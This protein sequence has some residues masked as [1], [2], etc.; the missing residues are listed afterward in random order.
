M[1]GRF[2]YITFDC[3]GT[4]IDWESGIRKAFV[5]AARDDGVRLDEAQII[6]L[7]SDVERVVERERYRRYR[8][9]LTE[10]ACRVAHALGW[11]VS[12]AGFLADSLASWKPFADTNAALE[13]LRTA[14][15][16][17]GI[18]S[19]VDDDLLTATR[20][21]FS[22]D[23]DVV[24]TAQH[25]GSYKPSPMHFLSARETIATAPWLHAAQSN[26]HDIVPTNALGIANA[27]INRKSNAPLPGGMPT[28][29]YA[30]LTQ[31]ANALT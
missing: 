6:P 1:S 13:R 30:D 5:E 14:G 18:L 23:F 7:Y 11:R 3:Y 4:L 31:L 21:H 19:N 8:D 20:R 12:Y 16:R 25:V 29:E 22:V 15:M 9:V 26:F 2:D 28:F 24:I 17:L 27:W 10:S